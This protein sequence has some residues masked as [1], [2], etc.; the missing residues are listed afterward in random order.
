MRL[1]T[2]IT[3]LCLGAI[4]CITLLECVALSNGINGTLQSLSVA[5]IVGLPTAVITRIVTKKDKTE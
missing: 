4:I 2:N 1:G 3:I 5:A